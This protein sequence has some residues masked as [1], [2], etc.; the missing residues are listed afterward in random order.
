[1]KENMEGGIE[2]LIKWRYEWC[3]MCERPNKIGFS[4][5]D[6]EWEKIV[7]K[8]FRNHC[9][10]YNCFELLSYIK[11]IP[12]TLLGLYPVA[13]LKKCRYVEGRRT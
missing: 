8:E 12:F 3:K 7:S 2:M 6:E 13:R 10:C 9:L 1:M 5:S 11:K 4:V